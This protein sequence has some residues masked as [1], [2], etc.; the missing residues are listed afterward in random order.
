[1]TTA[2]VTAAE[3]TS[4]AGHKLQPHPD[5][6]PWGKCCTSPQDNNF[7]CQCFMK[8]PANNS[9]RYEEMCKFNTDVVQ[10]VA[11]KGRFFCVHR[12]TDDGFHRECAGW[13]AKITGNRP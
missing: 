5:G 11:E 2:P 4:V 6:K 10:L 1:M 13:A 9:S 3:L 8:K 7:E 12:K